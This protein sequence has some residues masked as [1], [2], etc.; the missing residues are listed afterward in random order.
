M[1]ARHSAASTRYAN[2]F[3]VS[4][5]LGAEQGEA[6]LV[7]KDKLCHHGGRLA[8]AELAHVAAAVRAYPDLDE[9]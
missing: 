8:T 9:V 1:K 2:G 4:T 7:P 5:T 3:R 6:T